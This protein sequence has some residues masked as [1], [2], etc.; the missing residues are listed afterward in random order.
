MYL[1]NFKPGGENPYDYPCGI[2][3]LLIL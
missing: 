1:V 3:I 2:L